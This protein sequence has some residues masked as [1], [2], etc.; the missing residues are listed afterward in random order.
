MIL[1]KL[2]LDFSHRDRLEQIAYSEGW[3]S[4]EDSNAP[5]HRDKAVALNQSDR[6]LLLELALCESFDSSLTQYRWTRFESEGWVS[7]DAVMYR[8]APDPRFDSYFD[9]PLGI[10]LEDERL[11]THARDSSAALIGAFLPQMISQNE[12]LQRLDDEAQRLIIQQLV[13]DPHVVAQEYIPLAHVAARVADIRDSIIKCVYYSA[14]E[15]CGFSSAI[16]DNSS[17]EPASVHEALEQ[18]SVLLAQAPGDLRLPMP[19]SLDEA[20]QLR[21][22]REMKRFRKVVST[23]CEALQTGNFIDANR[24][25]GDI[26]KSSTALA[27]V[28]GI[29]RFLDR[30]INFAIGFGVDVVGNLV[31][32]IGWTALGLR[33]VRKAALGFGRT[34]HGWAGLLRQG[35]PP[36]QT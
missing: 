20:L 10:S 26:R 18:T 25:I 5:K 8:D 4:P 1:R 29:E 34:R 17:V 31:Q 35:I 30:P 24:L 3:I 19:N 32:P 9:L 14:R 2:F 23:W 28:E 11:I 13:T 22:T 36:Q 16:A 7:P 33:S 12:F 15:R 6:F 21:N 27:R